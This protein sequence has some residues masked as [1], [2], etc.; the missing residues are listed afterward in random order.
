[1]TDAGMQI[2]D[3][4]QLTGVDFKTVHRWLGGRTPYSR[5]RAS[6]AK[7]LGT[8]ERS[9]WPEM[10][11]PAPAGE[12]RREIVAAF[13]HADDLLAP[14]WRAMLRTATSH[15][16]LL[17]YTFLDIVKTPGVIDLLAAKAAAG[18]R[19]RI[20]ISAEDS[21]F[22]QVL[23]MERGVAD[24]SVAA[25]HTH[26]EIAFARGYLEPL[27]EQPGVE[28]REYVAN[29]FNSILR[30]DDEMLLTLHLWGT[31]GSQAPLLHLRRG[32]D[33]G[34]FERFAGH[35]DALWT[36]AATPLQPDPSVYPDPIQD[37]E[38]YQPPAEE[39]ATPNPERESER[40]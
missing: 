40:T 37:P 26:F 5:H 39:P 18:C 24:L 1:M 11:T 29:R 21:F 35:Y 14:D 12:D 13:A 32:S 28:V 38:R 16:D 30:V 7:A 19:V 17:D 10:D 8:D 6:I 4:A 2:D 27:L 15:I 33:E 3:L 23:D 20:M 9:L 34:L 25:S 22:V 36:D 31:P